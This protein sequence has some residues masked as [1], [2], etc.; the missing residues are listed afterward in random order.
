[1]VPATSKMLFGAVVPIPTFPADKIRIFS[2]LFVLK[3]KSCASVVPKKFVP[4]DVPEFPVNDHA[5][6]LAGETVDQ[7]K[8]PL[9]LLCRNWFPVATAPG[10]VSV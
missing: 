3:T 6:M 9:P 2:E 10:N 4:G 8:T 5:P 7:D 1:M